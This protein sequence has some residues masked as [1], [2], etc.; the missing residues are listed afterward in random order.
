MRLLQG[1]TSLLLLRATATGPENYGNL[2]CLGRRRVSADAMG[3]GKA[4]GVKPV[5]GTCRPII[6]RPSG[7]RHRRPKRTE[8]VI[9]APCPAVRG[10]DAPAGTWA[11]AHETA[12][13]TCTSPRAASAGTSGN[14]LS[15]AASGRPPPRRVARSAATETASNATQQQRVPSSQFFRRDSCEAPMRPR[16]KSRTPIA[17]HP[18]YSEPAST[19]Q[20][21]RQKRSPEYSSYRALLPPRHRPPLA[22]DSTQQKDRQCED[23]AKWEHHVTSFAPD[24]ALRR[25]YEWAVLLSTAWHHTN[26]ALPCQAM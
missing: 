12:A 20:L 26:P 22:S 7:C 8:V 9:D 25:G 24:G 5:A 14:R 10:E 3:Q 11:V 13:R 17:F 6:L 4:N 21:P 16:R 15:P 2:P 18:P 1:G 23:N 19:M